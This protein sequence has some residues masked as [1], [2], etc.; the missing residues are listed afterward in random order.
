M[1]IGNHKL[2]AAEMVFALGLLCFICPFFLDLSTERYFAL[3][4]VICMYIF[5]L[6]DA[7]CTVVFNYSRLWS[8]MKG[9][10]AF[11]CCSLQSPFLGRLAEGID[12]SA[13]YS[14]LILVTSIVITIAVLILPIIAYKRHLKE[15]HLG[16]TD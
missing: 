7:L 9:F 10:A 1:I 6:L 3:V 8:F 5:F 11:T 14:N 15:P 12:S 2:Y 4:L 13:V 16:R